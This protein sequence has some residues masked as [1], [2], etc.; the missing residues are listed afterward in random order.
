MFPVGETLDRGAF[1]VESH[2]QGEGYQQLYLGRELST[3]RDVL[4]AFDKVASIDGGAFKRSL[5]YTSPG[6]FELAFVG[7]LD[8]TPRFDLSIHHERWAIVERVPHG[9]WLPLHIGRIPANMFDESTPRPSPTHNKKTAL[10]DALS[11]GRSAG[12]ILSDAAS[13][14]LLLTR[15]RPELMWATR[16]EHLVVTGLSTRADAF[17]RTTKID[18]YSPPIFDRHYHAVEFLDADCDDSALVFPLAIMIAE[19]ATGCFPFATKYHSNGAWGG[20]H[21]R[22]A[23][24]SRLASLLSRG[25]QVDRSARPTLDA[26][27][28]EL[29]TIGSSDSP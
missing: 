25:M 22:L 13:Q 5:T 17:F 1:R 29:D 15:V 16:D 19:W 23:V 8:P 12:R 18:S 11:L 28:G 26:F 7:R 21:Q 20:Q 3:G 4:I 27:L 2:L 14:G 6:L 24:P 9:S 10:G